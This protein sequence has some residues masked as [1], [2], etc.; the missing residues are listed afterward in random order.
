MV[1]W[2]MWQIS[3]WFQV[4]ASV[5]A[6]WGRA[7]AAATEGRKEATMAHDVALANAASAEERC[8]MTEAGL[9]ALR[10][11]QAR[12][13][14]WEEELKAWEDALADRDAEL[15]QAAKDKAAEQGRPGKLKEDVDRA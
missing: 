4:N 14:E 7:E 3:G 1:T 11:E 12:L 10:E 2:R 6:A 13:Q 5:R 8:N 15:A 9:K